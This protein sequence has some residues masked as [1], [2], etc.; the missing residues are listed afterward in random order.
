MGG[1]CSIYWKDI[2]VPPWG[3]TVIKDIFAEHDI[4][5]DGNTIIG[6]LE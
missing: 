2:S 4:L 1:S 5:E 6:L 3:F